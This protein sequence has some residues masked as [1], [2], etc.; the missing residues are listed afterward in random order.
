ME[1]QKEL[2][3]AK[4]QLTK[5]ELDQEMLKKQAET[6]Q[7]IDEVNKNQKEVINATNM[8]N[9]TVASSSKQDYN[10]PDE[11][12]YPAIYSLNKAWTG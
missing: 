3:V 12:D 10:I 1:N 7:K 9:T 6:T 5:T 2:L 11:L 8:V 4:N